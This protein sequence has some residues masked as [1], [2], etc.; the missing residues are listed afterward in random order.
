MGNVFGEQ[1]SSTPQD[2]SARNDSADVNASDSNSDYDSQ[3]EEKLRRTSET[4]FHG[5]RLR[6]AG[7]SFKLSKSNAS[8]LTP[9]VTPNPATLNRRR[10]SSIEDYDSDTSAEYPR[11][12]ARGNNRH[13]SFRL[14]GI[15][16]SRLYLL[17][18]M[19]VLFFMYIIIYFSLI[20][21]EN[22]VKVSCIVS[23]LAS[24]DL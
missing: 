8:A 4:R 16:I 13:D 9:K 15:Y 5:Q 24:W 10:N 17:S 22:R 18:K 23:N 21:D 3:D 20:A 7:R 12:V 11:V 2:G 19:L 1:Q 6:D 14:Q